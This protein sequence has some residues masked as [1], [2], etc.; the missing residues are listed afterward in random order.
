MQAARTLLRLVTVTVSDSDWWPPII[1]L[2]HE[3]VKACA[4]TLSA[5]TPVVRPR[6]ARQAQPGQAPG[7][8][9]CVCREHRTL[10]I[11]IALLLSVFPEAGNRNLWRVRSA[12]RLSE[13]RERQCHSPDVLDD[14]SLGFGAA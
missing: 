7:R 1:I 10:D 11:L 9:G 13:E 6:G 2:S 14:A 8:I 5:S 12:A 3:I 4:L